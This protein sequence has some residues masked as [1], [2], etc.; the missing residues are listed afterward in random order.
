MR[1]LPAGLQ[2][3]VDAIGLADTVRMIDARPGERVTIPK[4]CRPITGWSR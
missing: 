2:D 4:H 1:D 3:V